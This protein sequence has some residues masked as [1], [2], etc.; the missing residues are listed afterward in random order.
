MAQQGLIFRALV[1]SPSDCTHERRIIPEVI[2]AWNAV[3]SVST[4]AIIEPVLWETHSRPALGS[5]PQELINQQLVKNCDLVIGAFWTRLGTPTGEAESGTAEEIEQFKAAG[6]PALLYFS[7]APVVPDSLDGAQYK[8]L[9]EYKAR[10]LQNGLCFK[11]ETLADFRDQLQRHLAA[12]MIEFLEAQPKSDAS[13]I[14]EGP[15][16]E[17][18]QRIALR[19][20]VA[21]FDSFLRRAFSD[22]EAERDS[23]PMGTDDGKFI[24]SRATD[25]LLH[26]KGMIQQDVGG[27]SDGLASVLKKLKTLQRH[28]TYLDG[29]VS[30][31]EFWD[32]GN[33][34]FESIKALGERLQQALVQ[35]GAAADRSASASL[36]Q[37]G[38]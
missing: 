6:R 13:T 7:S 22:W 19:R 21:D 25:E 9:S 8:A 20:L 35:Q 4:A 33:A 36:Q 29:G 28:Q 5:R 37:A 10:L 12:Q 34:I 26:F 31:Q 3:H 15:S 16:A 24:L 2:A 30:F 27:I 23:D 14:P 11:Y 1:A 38:G 32:E 17:S 18:E